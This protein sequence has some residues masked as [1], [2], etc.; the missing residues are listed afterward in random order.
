MLPLHTVT[1]A[2]LTNN[3]Y[4]NLIVFFSL[5]LCPGQ[6]ARILTNPTNPEVN[7]HVSL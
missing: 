6:L 1:S 2:L 5:I 4:V 3:K 7:D